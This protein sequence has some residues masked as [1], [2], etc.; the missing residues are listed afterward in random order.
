MDE[1]SRGYN[2]LVISICLVA[3]IIA[4]YWPVYKYNFVK[5]DDNIYITGNTHIKSGFNWQSIRWAFV[6]GHAAN[7]H[8]L[9]WISH[10]LDYQLFKGWAGGGHLVNVGFHILN[11]LLLFYILMRMTRAMWPSAFV[12]A[13]FALHPLHIESV[14]W[15]SERKD[16][17][18]TFFGLL[19]ILAY[20]NYVENKKLK[21]YL[22]AIVLFVLGLMSKPMLVTL[23]F[24][25]LLLDYWPLERKFSRQLLIEKIPFLIFSL[26]S[27]AVT[28]FVQRHGGAIIA[29]EFLG[30]K[31]RVYNG[32]VSYITYIAKMIWPDGLAVL[33]PHPGDEISIIKVALSVLLLVL[34]SIF[35]IYT[36]RRHKFFV[37]GWLWYIGTLVPVIGL[38]QVSVQA[39]ADRY[40]YMTLTG[41][42]IIIAWSAKE[43]V[44]PQRYKMLI[45]PVAA[46]LIILA[47]AAHA[48]LRYWENSITLFEHTLAVTKDN[49][50]I[51]NNYVDCLMDAGRLDDAVKQSNLIL[52]RKPGFGETQCNLGCALL[53]AGRTQEAIEHLKLAIEYK[54]ALSQAHYN[55]AFAL[56][57]QK[58]Y[59]LAIVSCRDALKIKP[60]YVEVYLCLAIIYN[61]M[62]KYDQVVESCNKAIEYEPNNIKAHYYLA[63]ALTALGKT[64]ESIKIYRSALQIEPNNPDFRRLLEKALKKQSVN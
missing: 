17:L 11:T 20:V 37:V 29:G 4:V 62:G 28:F 53:E 10:I 60:D 15:I 31:A 48:Q 33:Y 14:A 19:T 3:A 43:F 61:E 55:L 41:L 39:M 50:H 44:P 5:Y 26:A 21:W 51:L 7:W 32:I 8:P 35:F 58:K 2:P 23:P 34:I 64:D 12:A 22:A 59:D 13:V 45:L 40:T 6:S 54:P 18:S 38:V 25:L 57:E 24:V 9:T 56:T 36:A 63:A 52:K 42:F 47:A 30:L 46:V 16:L 49:Y 1:K 27:C